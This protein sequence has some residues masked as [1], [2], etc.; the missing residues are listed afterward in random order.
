MAKDAPA[1][2]TYEYIYMIKRAI[3]GMYHK[4]NR[5]HLGK[6]V[7][8]FIAKQNLRAADTI[9]QMKMV[10]Q[11]FEGKRLMYCELTA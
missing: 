11:S 7:A 2:D 10:V 1:T 8:E 3:M 4:V 9:E 6:Y 5:K